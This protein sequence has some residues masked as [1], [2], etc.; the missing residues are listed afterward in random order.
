MKKVEDNRIERA[1]PTIMLISQYME[2]HVMNF[3]LAS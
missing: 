3:F 1:I 2:L